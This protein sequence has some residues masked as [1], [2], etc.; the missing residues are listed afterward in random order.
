M[1]FSL[2]VFRKLFSFLHPVG[3]ACLIQHTIHIYITYLGTLPFLEHSAE[4]EFSTSGHRTG[5]EELAG[6]ISAQ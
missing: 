4:T 2:V 3:V 5:P 1:D 6:N